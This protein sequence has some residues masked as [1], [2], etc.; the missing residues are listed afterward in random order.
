MIVTGFEPFGGLQVNTSESVVKSLAASDR[1]VTAVLPTSYRRAEAQITELLRTHRPRAV[2]LLGLAAKEAAMRLE[3]VAL[4]L[5]DSAA[6]DN[7]G[8]VRLRRRIVEGAPV[9]YWSSLPL[10][11][12]ADD[13]RRLGEEVAYSRDAGGYVCNHVFFVAMHRVSS[14]F[15]ET[16]CGFVHLPLV[17]V[18]SPRLTRLADLVRIWIGRLSSEQA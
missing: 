16:R 12:M 14:E 17:P 6:A 4:N 2:I 10:E 13:A 5:D 11:Q 3:Q 7:D 15:P 9:G 8:D 1:V 18:P